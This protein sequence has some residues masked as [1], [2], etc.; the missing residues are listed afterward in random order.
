MKKTIIAIDPGAS[1]ALAYWPPGAPAPIIHKSH[2][3]DPLDALKDASLNGNCEVW[4]EDVPTFAGKALPGS[5]MF[6]LGKNCGIWEGIARGLGVPVRLT[7]PQD[8]QAGISGV[9]KLK[10]AE[11]KRALR[12]AASRVYPQV[13]VTLDNCDALLILDFGMRASNFNPSDN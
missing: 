2:D 5:A 12:T 13:K 11:R 3:T 9:G 8:W 1:G 4:I 10:G 7:R 6:R